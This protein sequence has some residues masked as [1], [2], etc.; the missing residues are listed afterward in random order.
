M[1]LQAKICGLKKKI[2]VESEREPTRS[3]STIQFKPKTDIADKAG[4]RR[5]LNAVALGAL[6]KFTNIVQFRHLEEA[7]LTHV[8]PKAAQINRNALQMGYEDA[9][10]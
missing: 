10:V 8:P 5:S 1:S 3:I 6:T 4:S 7:L 2:E 9:L